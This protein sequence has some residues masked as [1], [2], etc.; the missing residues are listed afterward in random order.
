MSYQLWGPESRKVISSNDL[1]FN[2]AKFHA[3]PQN[4]EGIKRFIFNEGGSC[5]S[6]QVMLIDY[7]EQMGDLAK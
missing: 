3:K 6:W 1:Y 7:G 4:I 5:T 2:E